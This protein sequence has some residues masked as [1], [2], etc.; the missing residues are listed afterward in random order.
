MY[1]YDCPANRAGSDSVKWV[2]VS[3]DEL[4][5]WVAD[6]DIQTPP[7]I[8]EAIAKRAAHPYFGYPYNHDELKKHVIAH[9]AKLYG[10]KVEPEWI[11]WVPSV[12]PGVVAAL[13]MTGGTFMYSVPM[14]DHIR[15]LYAEAKLPVI[16]VPMKRDI[17][18]RI[19]SAVEEER[20]SGS[21]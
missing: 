9:Y 10:A 17:I 2:V 4:P 18:D 11:V 8:I 1:N 16:E 5:M 6:M 7:E 13:Q 19:L 3:G 15:N 12:I 20:K 21:L 14:Y